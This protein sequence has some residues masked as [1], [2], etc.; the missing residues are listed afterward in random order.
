[1]GT[2]WQWLSVFSFVALFCTFF[3]VFLEPFGANWQK[4]SQA[5]LLTAVFLFS[6]AL[7][8]GMSNA[9]GWR[10]AFHGGL[11]WISSAGALAMF[12][13]GVMVRRLRRRNEQ[14]S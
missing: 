12:A 3:V 4:S 5:K 2:L 8:V 6:S 7:I 13:S 9:F 1:M 11:L 14:K 10:R